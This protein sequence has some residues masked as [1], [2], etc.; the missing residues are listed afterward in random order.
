MSSLPEDLP[1]PI[2]PPPPERAPPPPPSKDFKQRAIRQSQSGPSASE[3]HHV[4]FLESERRPTAQIQ[5]S[6]GSPSNQS[7]RRL[8]PVINDPQLSQARLSITPPLKLLESKSTQDLRPKKPPPRPPKL[9]LSPRS[10]PRKYTAA[11]E[12]GLSSPNSTGRPVLQTNV[13]PTSPINVRR[14]L[15]NER[16]SLPSSARNAAN[17]PRRYRQ[18]SLP[19]QSPPNRVETSIK[20]PQSPS[21]KPLTGLKG[22]PTYT[23]GYESDPDLPTEPS[24]SYR[25]PNSPRT[26]KPLPLRIKTDL[27]KSPTVAPLNITQ[28][29]IVIPKEGLDS[30]P[31]VE[32]QTAELNEIVDSYL[33]ELIADATSRSVMS[34]ELAAYL[35]NPLSAEE[36]RASGNQS[37]V[38]QPL[39]S[40]RTKSVRF[41]SLVRRALR[42]D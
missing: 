23:G 12:F 19:P 11:L 9:S 25:P 1:P 35:K 5:P 22:D 39:A 14:S 42:Q 6:P 8:G 20:S 18:P 30:L 7:R 10:P 17:N 38:T 4:K 33:D 32:V 26:D 36:E 31:P 21:A 29:S 40:G 27:S 2:A 28:R 15:P 3:E 13:G 37:P 16:F 41:V 34:P 24:P